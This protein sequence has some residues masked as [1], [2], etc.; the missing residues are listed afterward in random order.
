MEQTAKRMDTSLHSVER[1]AG[2]SG[3][4]AQK[5]ALTPRSKRLAEMYE[6]VKMKDDEEI[7]PWQRQLKVNRF[8]A[9]L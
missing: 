5:R 7:L 9:D 2:V 6:E 1:E 8:M 3:P 4:K